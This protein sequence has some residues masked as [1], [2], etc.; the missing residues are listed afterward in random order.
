MRFRVSILD[1]TAAIIVLVV[2]V[3]PERSFSV[4]HAYATMD[5]QLDELALYQAR[6]AANPGD[7]MAAEKLADLLIELDQEDWA[8]QVAGEA[9][10]HGDGTAWRA[11]LAVSVAH[12]S[13]FEVHHAHDFARRALEE[14]RKVGLDQCPVHERVRMSVFYDQL[15]AGVSS[16]I[17]PRIDPKGYHRAVLSRMRMIR[18]RG[19]TPDVPEDSQGGA[20]QDEDKNP[21]S[22]PGPAGAPPAQEI[23][24]PSGSAQ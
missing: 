10:N 22:G 8:V 5:R 19:G 3:L 20:G 11:L 2:I 9:A 17:D 13:R 24:P 14:C 23:P 15:D 12:A 6:L 7:A 16:G 21:G 18:V 1:L 4:S